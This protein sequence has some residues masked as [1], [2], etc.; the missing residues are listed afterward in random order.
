MPLG[1]RAHTSQ[2]QVLDVLTCVVDHAVELPTGWGGEVGIRTGPDERAV[3]FPVQAGPVAD[4]FRQGFEGDG[5][6]RGNDLGQ[7]WAR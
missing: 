3:H 1:N 7:S 5:E 4:R 2:F 6:W